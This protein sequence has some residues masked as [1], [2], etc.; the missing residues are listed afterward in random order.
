MPAEDIDAVDRSFRQREAFI[1]A[2]RA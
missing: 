2:R 1:V